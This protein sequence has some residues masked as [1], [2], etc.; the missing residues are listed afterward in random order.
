MIKYEQGCI[1]SN[2]NE[3]CY[4]TN[5]SGA[6]KVCTKGYKL[7]TISGTPKC[8]KIELGKCDEVSFQ[9]IFHHK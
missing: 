8:V 9:S 2:N 7:V 4:A 3:N 6:C 1:Q 5:N